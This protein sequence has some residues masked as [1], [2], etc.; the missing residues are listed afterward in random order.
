[1]NYF[2]R[3]G[4]KIQGKW[5]PVLAMA[6]G[7]ALVICAPLA[8]ASDSG[9]Q[10]LSVIDDT[11]AVLVH[12]SSGYLGVTIHDIDQGRATELHLKDLHGAEV[13]MLDHDAPACKAGVR[14]HDVILQMNGQA[15]E[16]V[17]QLRHM[18]HQTPV[19][20][21]VAFVLSRDGQPVTLSIQ[22]G[23]RAKLEQQPFLNPNS[24]PGAEPTERTQAF[25]EPRNQTDSGIG[26]GNTFIGRLE[27]NPLSVGASL[28][29]VSPQ[30]ADYFGVKSGT[31]LLVKNVFD[32]S[33][34]SAAGIKAGDIVLKVDGQT[35][36][37]LKD[38]THAIRTN[39]GKQVQVTVLRDHKEQTVTMWAGLAKNKG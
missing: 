18:L 35:M 34:A 26:S 11:P 39:R 38:W 4:T 36:A 23:D 25:V 29:P 37:K 16:N 24:D 28:D 8:I 27:I 6:A 33:A 7:A 30:L 31:G 13:V 5:S 15:V 1:M 20:R 10:F 22:L 2:S 12:G 3:L 21:T 19:G 9:V 14:L 32:N 17:E